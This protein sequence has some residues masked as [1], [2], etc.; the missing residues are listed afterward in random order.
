MERKSKSTKKNTTPPF[1]A[2][3]LFKAASKGLNADFAKIRETMPHYATAGTE[4]ENVLNKFLNNHLPR[5]FAAANGIAID[6]ED[7]ISQQFDTLIYDAENNPVYRAGEGFVAQI[8]PSDSIAAAIE[9]KSN[10]NKEELKDAAEKIA[11]IKR[12]KRSPISNHDQQVNFSN[13]I[14]ITCLGVVFAYT[15]TTS[16]KTLAK[17]LKEINQTIPKSQRIDLVVVL[18]KGVIG[19]IPVVP[20]ESQ[21]RGLIMM[22]EATDDFKIP[23]WYI[24]LCIFEEPDHALHYFFIHLMSSIA[25]FRKR[26]PLPFD[27]LLKGAA[28]R[29]QSIQSY[30]YNCDRDLVEVPIEHSQKKNPPLLTF[31]VFL[32]GARNLI[33]QFHQHKWSDGYIYQV[34]PPTRAA[35]DVLSFIIGPTGQRNNSL[36]PNTDG[37]ASYTTLLKGPPPV[38][39]DI[40][41]FLAQSPFEIRD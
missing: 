27:S 13:F 37:V 11:S 28:N 34:V 6:S 29:I 25:F 32:K 1:T 39:G 10:L 2:E 38:I 26:I 33:G 22:P 3:N 5:R 12:L 19:Y 14:S 23:A 7:N 8:L 4:T 20:G 9:I 36:V 21:A 31:N 16:L 30:W 17:N 18:D 35:L 41:K 40:K 15:S 24:H